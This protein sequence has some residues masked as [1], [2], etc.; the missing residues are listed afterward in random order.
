M[1]NKRGP[2]SAK[3]KEFIK[4][5]APVLSAK[6]I[7]NKLKRNS[8]AVEKYMRENGLLKTAHKTT[9]FEIEN[10]ITRSPHWPTIQKQF[11]K[12]EQETFIYN[13]NNTIKQFKDDV[14]HTEE[15]QIIDSIK[16]EIMMNRLLIQEKDVLDS[17]QNMQVLIDVEKKLEPEDR[18]KTLILDYERQISFLR[19]SQ[20]S[21]GKEYRELLQK[22]SLLFKEMKATREARIKYLESNKDSLTGWVRQILSDREL[23]RELGIEMEKMRLAMEVEYE[24]LSE[25]HI[26]GDGVGDQ[27]L[28]TPEN[29]KEG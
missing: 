21:I 24:K 18:D 4:E 26:Y 17:I 12:E 7:A 14:L 3:E 9:V 1:E 25:W 8:D 27:P 13:W 29:V 20:E 19:A 15:L 10:D 11:T 22:K 28:L 2:W 16:I 6:D 23:R 5:F